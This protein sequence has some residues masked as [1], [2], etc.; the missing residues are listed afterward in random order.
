MR[1]T[2]AGGCCIVPRDQGWR[3]LVLGHFRL[4]FLVARLARRLVV[5]RGL[6]A[7]PA[8]FVCRME[9]LGPGF[10]SCCNSEC[11]MAGGCKGWVGIQEDSPISWSLSEIQ[12]ALSCS[13]QAVTA[14]VMY[15]A[16]SQPLPPGGWLPQPL[17]FGNVQASVIEERRRT[18]AALHD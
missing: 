15:D 7:S 6:W 9:S 8:L 3:L 2:A 1:N 18:Q 5:G 11:C 4:C 12:G 16:L 17:G 10:K 13:S 14:G